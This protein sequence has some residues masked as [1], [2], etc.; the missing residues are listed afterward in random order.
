[1]GVCAHIPQ[2]KELEEDPE[3]ASHGYELTMCALSPE[4]QQCPGLPQK[5]HGQQLLLLLPLLLSRE[6]SPGVLHP[7]LTSLV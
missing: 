2:M 4:Y 5:Q 6:T 7:D 3:Q 1:M